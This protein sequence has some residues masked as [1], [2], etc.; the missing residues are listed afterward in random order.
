MTSGGREG[1][2]ELVVEVD[3]SSAAIDLHDKRRAYRRN[4]V[5]WSPGS[6]L[7]RPPEL[8]GP[9]F[10]PGDEPAAPGASPRD[11]LDR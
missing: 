5:R 9:G 11:L 1:A 2:P 3:A 10:E 4:G 7:F 8:P 6:P